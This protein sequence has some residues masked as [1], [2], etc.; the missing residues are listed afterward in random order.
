M[1]SSKVNTF[2]YRHS[3]AFIGV[4]GQQAF[5][6]ESS[7][8]DPVG[9]GAI[10]G[11][12]KQVKHYKKV[13]KITGGSKIE[14]H[15][16][17]YKHGNYARVLVNEK[18]VFPNSKARRGINIVAL[19]FTNHKV[20][21]TGSY[22][23]Y[24]DAGA[25]ARLVADFKD[26]T[27]IPEYCI[28]VAGV[29]DEASNKLSKEVKGLFKDLGSKQI[30]SLKFREGWSFIG[31]KGVQKSSEKKGNQVGT[32]MII[33][34]GKVTQKEVRKQIKVKHEKVK[35]GS[36][37]EV[38]SA[39]FKHGNFA[40]INVAGKML[41]TR[42]K[43]RRGL[44]VVALD[45]FK[46]EVIG[47]NSYDTYGDAK[48]SKRFVRDFKRLPTG[49]V[50][51]IG[52]RDEASKR[53]SGEARDV[54]KALGSQ[55]IANLGFR[56]GFAFIGVKGQVKFLE[57]RG[58]SVGT[59][60]ILSYATVEKKK[61]VRHKVDGGSSIEVVSAGWKDGN[62]AKIMLNGE[63]I[64]TRRNSSSK[65]AMKGATMSSNYR[66]GDKNKAAALA[67]DSDQKSY[68]HTKCGADEWWSAQ[69]GD[70]YLVT[71]VKIQNRFQGHESSLRRLQNAE[72]TIEG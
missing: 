13:T 25:S 22:D 11:Y 65:V 1:G 58:D 35:G 66:K 34:Y 69:F 17:G 12:A 10:L 63:Q 14:V 16:A 54:I 19:D 40:T 6:E 3:W 26:T 46:H 72:V 56:Q 31:V 20:V 60:A 29:K 45:P 52:V 37:I 62:I 7:D 67:L 61:E 42:E 23:T 28:I 9:T 41:V 71:E 5:T 64:L 55:E 44:N 68:F 38:Q 57:K 36:R 51:V 33:G 27:K 47:N 21:Y 39:G 15:S 30:S 53:L 43:S 49:A 18:E 50:I 24:G 4:K 59:G 2:K 48:A 32:A 8:K 70:K